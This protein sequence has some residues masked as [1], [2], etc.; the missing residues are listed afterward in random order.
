[1][2]HKFAFLDTDFFLHYVQPQDADWC[3]F[4]SSDRVTLLVSSMVTDQLDKHKDQHPVRG[5][6]KRAK[7]SLSRINEFFKNDMTAQLR[8]GVIV[9]FRAK[10]PLV[11]YASLGLDRESQDDRILADILSFAQENPTADLL[12]ITTDMGFQIKARS[13]AVRVVEPPQDWRLPEVADPLEEE[14]RALKKEVEQLRYRI[15]KL[16]LCFKG[17]STHATIALKPKIETDAKEVMAKIEEFRAA[18]PSLKFPLQRE[19]RVQTNKKFSLKD[20]EGKKSVIRFILPAD[21]AFIEIQGRERRVQ[22]D[23]LE[24]YNARINEFYESVEKY[25]HEIVKYENRRRLQLKIELEIAN[26]GSCPAEDVEL[27]LKFPL[28]F[29][30]AEEEWRNP[31]PKRPEPPDPPEVITAADSM[32]RAYQESIG[33]LSVLPRLTLPPV[34]PIRDRRAPSIKQNA[35]HYEVAFSIGKLKHGRKKILRPLYILFFSEEGVRHI[36]F[37]YI[38]HAD[39]LVAT[40]SGNLSIRIEPGG[41]DRSWIHSLKMP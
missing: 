23:A 9:E 36:R 31:S 32:A 13:H 26:E 34:A 11:D 33:H 40:P 6:R 19:E 10:S 27:Y 22:K 7:S 39:N 8:D 38:I 21:E 17:G 18:Y 2:T 16:T 30:L 15:P 3:K 14:N 37:T 35:D 25:I 24:K 1:M 12:L 20:L 5:L 28:E 29:H 41:T 4:L